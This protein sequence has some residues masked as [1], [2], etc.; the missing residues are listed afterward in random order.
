[1]TRVSFRVFSRA[2]R[3]ACVAACGSNSR[4]ICCS[5]RVLRPPRYR[6]VLVLRSRYAV[7]PC[8]GCAVF[9]RRTDWQAVRRASDILSS[10]LAFLQSV[11]QR[12]LAGQPQ[13]P[14]P[15]MDFPSLQHMQDSAIHS[16]RTFQARFVPSSGFGY[17][18]DGFLPPKPGQPCF[19]LA[20]L[21]GFALRSV[22]LHRGGDASPRRPNP[23]AVSPAGYSP[24]PK[25]RAGPA[26][27][28]FRAFTL[29]Q[30]PLRRASD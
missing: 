10:S 19:M 21:M 14:A 23:R 18:L 29:D 20:A 11:A 8:P 4:G 7:G 12:T 24:S 17:P 25:R 1:M 13:P 6:F 27:R 28:G 16:P 22:L 2:A 30:S 26:G 5:F 9:P 3:N 15:L